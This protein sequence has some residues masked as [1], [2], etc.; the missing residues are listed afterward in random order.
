MKSYVMWTYDKSFRKL[1]SGESD[2]LKHLILE[3]IDHK[4]T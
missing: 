4:F 1:L 3:K 2:L